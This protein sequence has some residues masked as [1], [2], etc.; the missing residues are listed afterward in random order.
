MRCA[1]G[2]PSIPCRP[3]PGPRVVG[4]LARATMYVACRNEIC[5]ARTR[6]MC[7]KASTT[8]IVAASA[9]IG[10]NSASCRRNSTSRWCFGASW[11]R[12]EHQ[13]IFVFLRALGGGW[14]EHWDSRHFFCKR[15]PRLAALRVASS[16]FAF[17]CSQMEKLHE[18]QGKGPKGN[19]TPKVQY[20][21]TVSASQPRCRRPGPS[22]SPAASAQQV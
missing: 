3:C 12:T 10:V 8:V 15:S 20:D 11:H 17:A 22:H 5:Y 21:N 9:V 18:P 7:G 1:A 14:G 6:Y 4:T 13:D 2:L 19:F 16:R